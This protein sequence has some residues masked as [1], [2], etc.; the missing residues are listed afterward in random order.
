MYMYFGQNSPFLRQMPADAHCLPLMQLLIKTI[1]EHVFED[2][3]ILDLYLCLFSVDAIASVKKIITFFLG[4]SWLRTKICVETRYRHE[5][6]QADWAVFLPSI[7]IP[8]NDVCWYAKTEHS[9]LP[10]LVFNNGRRNNKTSQKFANIFRL[11]RP[12]RKH[13]NSEFHCPWQTLLN[14]PPICQY[15]SRSI[16]FVS[17]NYFL[18]DR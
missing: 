8:N 6:H 18:Q 17:L 15:W 2:Q 5:G 1:W 16:A 9:R 14:L 11:S 7:L 10:T 3:L 12:S 4:I 13:L